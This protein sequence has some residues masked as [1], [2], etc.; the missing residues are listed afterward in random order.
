M[1]TVFALNAAAMTCYIDGDADGYGDMTDAGTEMASCFDDGFSPTHDDCDDTRADVY[2]GAA[3]LCDGVDND[4]N[5]LDDAGNPGVDGW[6][7]DNDTDGWSECQGDCDDID[8]QSY[9]GNTEIIA[10]YHDENCDGQELCYLDAD[11][12]GYR[13]GDG[14]G[15]VPSA[16]LSCEDS[17]EAVAADPTGDCNDDNA[18]IHPGAT[19]VPDDGIDQDCSGADALSDTD[20]DGIND[21]VETATGTDPEDADTDNDGLL[22]GQED[23]NGDG[24]P[25]ASETD[26]RD[27]DTDNDGLMDG[28]GE[29]TNLDGIVG[30]GETDPLQSDSDGDALTDGLE[31]GKDAAVPGGM[32][33]GS[34]PVSY[35]GTDGWTPD[36][37][38]GTMTDPLDADT[39]ADGLNDGSE[40]SNHD[41]AVNG[42]ETDPNNPD[43]DGDGVN[44]GVDACPGYND[45]ADFD[46][47]GIP[48]SCDAD[49]DNDQVLDTDEDINS[50]GNFDDDDTDSDGAPDYHDEDD[51]GD[52][53]NTAAED[54]NVNGDPMDDDT[55]G[56]SLANYL[57]ED[58]DNDLIAT[59]DEDVNGDGNV[60]NDDTDGNGIPNYLDKD[61]DG[62]GV[63]TASEDAN[64]NGD[65]TD[66]DTDGDGIADYL[67]NDTPR[68]V[69]SGKGVEIGNYASPL[70]SNG[71]DFGNICLRQNKIQTFVIGNSGSG[72]L[73]LGAPP[74]SLQ[75][76]IFYISRLSERNITQGSQSSFDV[77]LQCGVEVAYGDTV[78]INTMN[79]DA[80]H[81]YIKGSCV[82]SNCTHVALNDLDETN[83]YIYVI[84][85]DDWLQLDDDV[86]GFIENMAAL[87][88]DPV[89]GIDN[90]RDGMTDENDGGGDYRGA[91]VKVGLYGP[92][93]AVT[94]LDINASG[95]AIS[96]DS[97]R[98]KYSGGEDEIAWFESVD[99]NLTI[100]FGAKESSGTPVAQYDID[101]ILRGLHI[102][103]LNHPSGHSITLNWKL[104]DSEN[105]FVEKEHFLSFSTHD[106]GAP[107]QLND[108]GG[109]GTEAYYAVGSGAVIFMDRDVSA[110]IEAMADDPS[111]PV[112]GLDNDFDGTTDENITDGDYRHSK[113]KIQ[114]QADANASDIFGLKFDENSTLSEDGYMISGPEPI[115]HY[116]NSA[117]VLTITFD[118]E[119]YPSQANVDE[120]LRAVTYKNSSDANAITEPYSATFVWTL[121]DN[122]SNR[123][124]SETMTVPF[125]TDV[126][127]DGLQNDT[128]NCPYDPNADQSDVDG[129]DIGDVC[130]A[131]AHDPENDADGDG[132]GGDTDNCP[133]EANADQNDVDGDGLGDVCDEDIDGDLL[134]NGNDNCPYNANA[135][136]SDVDSDDY[137]DVCDSCPADEPLQGNPFRPAQYLSF[138]AFKLLSHGDGLLYYVSK[139]GSYVGV[140]D[141]SAVVDSFSQDLD[142]P[143]GAAFD[144][145]GRLYVTS[146]NNQKVVLFDFNATSG[147]WEHTRS[148]SLSFE[149]GGIAV[150]DDVMYVSNLS[151]Y[152]IEKM[153]LDGTP[154]LT[155][156]G[157]VI[158]GDMVMG[159]DHS[160]F[161]TASFINPG[162]NRYA[163]DGTLLDHWAFGNINFGLT[164]NDDGSLTVAENDDNILRTFTQS[165]TPV[166][167]WHEEAWNDLSS[168]VTI[169]TRTYVGL[170]YR[171]N[172]MLYRPMHIDSDGDGTADA[173]DPFPN[174]PDDDSDGDGVG[175]GDNCPSVA[176]PGQ[177]DIDGDGIGDAC[178][179]NNSDGPMADNDG[180]GVPNGD[181]LYP[182]D[183]PLG[184]WDGDGIIN[185]DDPDDTD[186]LDPASQWLRYEQ[187]TSDRIPGNIEAD[188]QPYP[189]R[190][191]GNWGS[192]CEQGTQNVINGTHDG[193]PGVS[194]RPVCG[195]GEVLEQGVGCVMY[196]E[197][198][199]ADGDGYFAYYGCGTLVDCDD[200]I[201][202]IN[203][204]GS[205]TCNGLD[206]DC[207]G[208]TDEPS[209]LDAPLCGLQAG[210]CSG[211][212][213]QCVGGAWESCTYEEVPGYE[214]EEMSC[215]DGLDNDCDG[216][217]DE[218]A[219]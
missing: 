36:A 86:S 151:D 130:D 65:P 213:Q 219:P 81:F 199:D 64:H 15:T 21:T 35:A 93:D 201:F 106:Y 96:G 38:T 28:F 209:E 167:T 176:N 165:G 83:R 58:D 131:F 178:D 19:D 118:E 170:Y 216:L 141:G 69:L 50:N 70:A 68:M 200:G 92:D 160:L 196:G 4:C 135:D 30:P 71:T 62:D 120:V 154:L 145:D 212:E 3:E 149:P 12:D 173:C 126:D 109:S 101:N 73:L 157:T 171:S 122:E 183:G 102:K 88:N 41:G 80:F 108:L 211:Y 67:D 99:G 123:S 203:P 105:I 103:I 45:A 8:K 14:S 47:D 53:V 169:G 195:A 52:S 31:S 132:I 57:D 191:C 46:S 207:D 146:S 85:S 42:S 63:D 175:G 189:E 37:D 214:V 54:V 114:R 202:E 90:D 9:P 61:D 172:A 91:V 56:D 6:E 150:D 33:D 20:G 1:M 98:R 179:D 32:S 29:D 34:S 192:P 129:D 117:G 181:D 51:D 164:R 22:D 194:D 148:I 119:Q 16:N 137:G 84:G 115:G 66:D 24:V 18:S 198:V 76:G 2:P 26:P 134:A 136:Q 112:D 218:C 11:D 94:S 205:E 215:D 142:Q 161:V 125:N 78:D 182:T 49:D 104:F 79:T 159:D 40:D 206:D 168:T 185:A 127:G 10:N 204:G 72:A 152:A 89:D 110:Y 174:D 139:S 44:D 210:V 7:T 23:V 59:R 138:Y 39:D 13:P 113:L 5:G 208:S 124:V 158:A 48:D 188:T 147:S 140:Y 55:D 156:P 77:L 184:D 27:A 25:D 82:E 17:G 74:Q 116:T 111:D 107:P 143:I 190:T 100:H 60:T 163:A 121:T 187:G 166:G 97:I 95:Y 155:F 153:A 162:I 128:D 186:G 180:D 43:S 144:A 87:S 177:E 75:S 217:T 197:C 193:D 133:Y